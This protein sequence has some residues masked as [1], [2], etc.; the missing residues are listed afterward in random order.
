MVKNKKILGILIIIGLLLTLILTRDGL[1]IGQLSYN[2]DQDLIP[3]KELNKDSEIIEL[4]YNR[5]SIRE[6]NSTQLSRDVISKVIWSTVGINADGMSGPTRATPSAGATNPLVIYVSVSNVDELDKGLYRYLPKQNALKYEVKENISNEISEAAI[7]QT[8]VKEAPVSLI[9]TAN[10]NNTTNKYGERGIKYV[11]IESGA[12]AQNALLTAQNYGLG[13][14][15]IGAFE[16][17]KL[18]KIM[19]DISEEPL[20]ILPFGNYN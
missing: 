17:E 8:A 13:G 11:H 19:G 5:S 14:V 4:I 3:L 18:K 12:A 6:Y 2:D 16:A 1:L 15:I 7:N 20:L 10:Y 9:I